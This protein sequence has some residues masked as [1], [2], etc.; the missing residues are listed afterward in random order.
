MTDDLASLVGLLS[1]VPSSA[2]LNGGTAGI[3]VSGTLITADA[4]G[5]FGPLQPGTSVVLRF[6]AT[7]AGSVPVGT[8]SRFAPEAARTVVE[9]VE[10][11]VGVALT[12]RCFW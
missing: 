2:T 6:R 5:T 1:F 4:F 10:P 3:N 7:I 11:E 12:R 8:T 9:R